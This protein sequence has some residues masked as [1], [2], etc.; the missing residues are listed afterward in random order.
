MKQIRIEP[1]PQRCLPDSQVPLAERLCAAEI[2]KS[3]LGKLGEEYA[4]HCLRER[5]WTIANRN[6]RTRYGEIDIVAFTPTRQL[7]FCEVKT[8][9]SHAYG[10]AQEAVNIAKQH[11]LRL[12]ALE[13]FAAF[14]Y[15]AGRPGRFDV[16]S[17]AVCPSAVSAQL[18]EGAF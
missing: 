4:T 11:R 5:G 3:E 7:V 13:W 17:I 8:R 16:F 10:T 1:K 14:P 2:T 15:L 9:R 6:F 18:L 12:A